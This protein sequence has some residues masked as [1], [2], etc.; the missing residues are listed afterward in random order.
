VKHELL[1]NVGRD[2]SLQK[3]VLPNLS[4]AF[5]ALKD[6]RDECGLLNIL[7]VIRSF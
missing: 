1:N 7:S 4:Y 2:V 6:K 3:K 5:H